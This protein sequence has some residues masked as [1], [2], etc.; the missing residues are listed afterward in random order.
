MDITDLG[1]VYNDTSSI[2]FPLVPKTF[3]C[4]M[5][6]MQICRV[7]T[8][9]FAGNTVIAWIANICAVYGFYQICFQQVGSG[10]I[11]AYLLYEMHA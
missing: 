6:K 8:A 3:I 1:D 2:I 7:D 10:N 9:V 4:E 11:F 5:W